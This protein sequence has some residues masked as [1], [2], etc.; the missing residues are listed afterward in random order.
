MKKW[1]KNR[2]SG[3][4]QIDKIISYEQFTTLTSP[5]FTELSHFS[6]RASKVCRLVSNTYGP[7]PL[8]G[9]LALMVS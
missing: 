8:P 6:T 3:L 7:P 5:L 4:I 9:R 2:F 1:M